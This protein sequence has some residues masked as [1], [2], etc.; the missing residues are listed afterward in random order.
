MDGGDRV[1]RAGAVA[2]SL[3][4]GRAGLHEPVLVM[5][6]DIASGGIDG[7]GGDADIVAV[8]RI[9]VGEALG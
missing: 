7:Q 8:A 5:R 9:V 3:F 2:E 4:L 6:H 1:Q